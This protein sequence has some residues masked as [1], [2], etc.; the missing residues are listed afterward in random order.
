MCVC[1][2]LCYADCWGISLISSC[3]ITRVF[4]WWQ[5]SLRLKDGL[6]DATFSV[7]TQYQGTTRCHCNIY[8]WQWDDHIVV[9]DIDGTITKY[10]PFSIDFST[11]VMLCFDKKVSLVI[12]SYELFLGCPLSICSPQS[13]CSWLGTKNLE[14]VQNRRECFSGFLWLHT[15][16][17]MKDQRWG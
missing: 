5:A 16:F 6:N 15:S 3:S 9:S 12:C 7:T 11:Y 14:K 2:L 13:V 17:E 8:L 1:L 10:A 4:A